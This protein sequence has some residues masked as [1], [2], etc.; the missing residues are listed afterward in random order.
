MKVG[1]GRLRE[2]L[3]RREDREGKEGL[4]WLVDTVI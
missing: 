1:R 3:G 4:A 2:E